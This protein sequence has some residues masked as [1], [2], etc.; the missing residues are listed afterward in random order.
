MTKS[1]SSV[2]IAT[3]ADHA[4]AEAAVKTLTAA[5]FEPGT[6]S[7]IG[8]GYH[9]E[10]KV[11][12]FYNTGERIKIWGKQGAFWGGLW[13]ALLGGLMVTAPVVGPVLIVGY[14]GAVAVTAIESAVLVGG[15]SAI[16]AAIYSIGVPRDSV[17]RY[18]TSVKADGFLVM[19]HGDA[20][21]VAKAKS[22]LDATASSVEI[23]NSLTVP[24]QALSAA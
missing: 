12:G 5:G 13:G 8:K 18:E 21:A 11:L 9:T 6:L 22:I 23:H 19:V 20:E 10:E 1:Y 2:A 3:F 14:L 17:L 15:A 4:G 7:V 16:G 24:A